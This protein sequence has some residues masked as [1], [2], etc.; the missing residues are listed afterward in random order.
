MATEKIVIENN[1]LSEAVAGAMMTQDALARA[2]DYLG[3]TDLGCDG[4]AFIGTLDY[5]TRGYFIL[6]PRTVRGGATFALAIEE[7]LSVIPTNRHAEDALEGWRSENCIFVQASWWTPT[8]QFA[9]RDSNGTLLSTHN[10]KQNIYP[11]PID[12]GY[13]EKCVTVD[14]TTGEEIA[15]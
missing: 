2:I 15:A 14:L 12:D 5:K 10:C 11:R 1:E 8:Q 4:L 3:A 6:S 13:F 9:V 7:I